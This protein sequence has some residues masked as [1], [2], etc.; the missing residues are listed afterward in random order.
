MTLS[1]ILPTVNHLSDQDKLRLIDFLLE[2]VAKEEGCS[3]EI[4]E[5]KAPTVRHSPTN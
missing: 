5:V 4:S 3:L 2:T 1:E